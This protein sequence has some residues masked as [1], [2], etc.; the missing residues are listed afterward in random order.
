MDVDQMLK[1][2]TKRVSKI[3]SKDT[4]VQ[5]GRI[6]T[7]GGKSNLVPRTK[8]AVQNFMSSSLSAVQ[9]ATKT[10]KKRIS[11]NIGRKTKNANLKAIKR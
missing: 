5:G 1:T 3:Q 8:A 11:S 10:I 4:D 7:A 6:K 9:N 2:I